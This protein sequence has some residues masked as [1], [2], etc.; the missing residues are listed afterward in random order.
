MVTKQPGTEN[1]G[2]ANAHIML[3]QW[4]DP[5]LQG[6]LQH[7]WMRMKKNIMPE[8]TWLQLHRCF[9]PSFES[10]LDRGVNEGWYDSSNM[11]QV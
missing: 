7:H 8:I 10:I 5:A 2:I 4:H 6:I 11:L 3:W 1:Y 9:T